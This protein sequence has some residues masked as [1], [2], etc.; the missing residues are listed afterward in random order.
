MGERNRGKQPRTL[1]GSV[2]S[3]AGIGSAHWI[4]WLRR[5]E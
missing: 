5:D 1:F 4:S 2:G 3:R